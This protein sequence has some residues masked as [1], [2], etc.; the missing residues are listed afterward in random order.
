MSEK[1]RPR[2][3]VISH[4]SFTKSD[5]MGGTLASYFSEY[6]A[7]CL[8][9]FYIKDMKPDI[10]VCRNYYCVTDREL[11]K[12][13]LCPWSA[14]I[15]NVL[16]Y[17]ADSI[18]EATGVGAKSAALGR[19]KYRDAAMIARYFLW[20][21]NVWRNDRF[22]KWLLEVDPQ[23]VLVQPGDFPFI[24]DLAVEIS[25]NL[26]I[27]LVMHQSEA[28]YLKEYEKCSV[29]KRIYL[30]L[31]RKSY[32]RMMRQVSHTVYLCEALA[33]DYQKI[34]SS[35]ASTIMKATNMIPER[36]SRQFCSEDVRFVYGGNLSEV[37]GRHEPLLQLGRA[38]RK[39]GFHIDVYTMST[40]A[41]LKDFTEENGICLH[42]GVSRDELQAIM[43]ESDFVIHAEN[44]SDWHKQ[45]LKY[46][47][48][49][50]IADM[51]AS[52]CCALVFGSE[53]IASIRYFKENQLGFVLEDPNLLEQQVRALI[54]D[55]R[56]RERYIEN[57]LRQAKDAHNPITNSVRMMDIIQNVWDAAKPE[58]R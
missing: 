33:R 8:S 24:M 39:N 57:A 18:N 58:D 7:E 55:H 42:P 10:P 9:Q 15:G 43:K 41:H 19:K 3:L 23:V 56:G 52:G 5:S 51:L 25:R 44:Q 16:Q 4:T 37:V 38:I 27:P 28:Y 40:G 13:V 26:R 11:L 17:D 20:K 53:E 45:D 14:A 21:T 32:E 2:I 31:F 29:S 36:S 54:E 30:R 22:K 50:K 12:K 6:P 49:T 46:A 48:S 1:N 47:M 35:P 34:F